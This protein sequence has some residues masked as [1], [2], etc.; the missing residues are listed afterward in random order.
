MSLEIVNLITLDKKTQLE[1]RNWRNRNDIRK[2]M[3][4]QNLITPDEHERWL[5]WLK[6]TD[7]ARVFV[8]FRGEEPVGVV[9][10][11]SIDWNNR[12]AD[13]G[14]Y[15]LEG[16][17]G[18]GLSVLLLDKAFGE[19]DLLKVRADYIDGNIRAAHLYLKLG[20]LYEGYRPWEI[21]RT[22]EA[23]QGV[24]RGIGLLLMGLTRDRWLK[25]RSKKEEE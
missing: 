19:Y 23:A 4:N 6:D 21:V 7:K 25:Y 24:I 9:N 20:F 11:S 18:Y 5:K 8:G 14:I 17:V 1:V 13:F 10:L 16:G 2:W 12:T 3:I 22:A 15:T